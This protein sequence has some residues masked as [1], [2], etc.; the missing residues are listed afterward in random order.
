MRATPFERLTGDRAGV[1]RRLI[2][3][4]LPP[5]APVSLVTYGTEVGDA[6]RF[7][8]VGVDLVAMGSAFNDAERARRAAVGEAV[9]RYCGNFV[10]ASGLRQ[11][12]YCEL[13]ASGE[14]AIDPLSLAL[15][16]EQQHKAPGFPFVPFTREL[17]V[18]WKE[19]EWMDGSQPCWVPASLAYINFYNGT[20]A[21]ESPTNFVMY[22]GVAA[23]ESREDAEVSAMLELI[24]R[25]ATMVWWHS[26]SACERIDDDEPFVRGLL[27][28]PGNPG[29]LRYHIIRIPTR[30][31]FPVMGVLCEDTA[32]S[33]VT[34]GMACRVQPRDALAKAAAEAVHLWTFALG[35]LDPNGHVWEAIERGIFDARSYQPYRADRTYRD[36][37]RADYRDMV[38]LGS[39]AQYFLDPRTHHLVD[40]IRDAPKGRRLDD[41]CPATTA[42]ANLRD[43][44]V[45]VLAAEGFRP[46]SVELTTS[47]VAA[48]G[49]S[50]VRVVAPGLVP[51]GPAAFPFL[52]GRRLREEPVLLGLAAQILQED[53][54]LL[55]PLPHT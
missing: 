27:A 20:H 34:L 1:I 45:D 39:N 41:L 32:R 38:D 8:G 10:P 2:R 17:K 51:N 44:V 28:S 11:A 14:S 7:C 31:P 35:L 36:G 21:S 55:A 16:S 6:R 5:E 3:H 25:D 26:G 19:A 47:D 12:S 30:Y 9:E 33:I 18:L 22:S 13:L 4:G 40:R 24:E 43:F 42:S 37:Y 54:L 52:G 53:D 46:A 23:G 49:L 50:V 48:A 29:T 15:Y